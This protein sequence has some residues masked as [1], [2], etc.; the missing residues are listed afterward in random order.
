[1]AKAATA[2]K[3]KEQRVQLRI[4]PKLIPVFAGQAD[5][6]GAKGGR[7]S[8]KTRTFAKMAALF[9]LQCAAKGLEGVIVCGR[10]FM[11]SL[12]DSS[13]A[14]V[15]FAIAEEPW[16]ASRYDVGKNYIRTSD[17]KISFV[18]A[19]LRHNIESIKSK[20]RIRLLWVDEAERVSDYAW[21]ITIPTIREEGAEVWVT[22]NPA[23][24]KSATHKRFWLD[25]PSNSKIVELNWRD[26]PWFPSRL[27]TTRLDDLEKRPDQYEHVWEGGFVTVVEGAY[28][29]KQIA[30]AKLKGRI[31]PV[32]ADPY[33]PL[34]AFVDIGG[35]GARS[36]AVSIF[37]AQFVATRIRVL[38]YYE[39]QGQP[40][41]TH[42]QW[43]RDNKF[44]KAFV[45]LPHDGAT[46]DKVHDVSYESAFRAAQF[47]V[48][49]IPNQGIGAASFRIEALRR[50]FPSID[51]NE[52][53]IT[54]FGALEA[55]GWYHEKRS[56]DDRDIGLGPDHDWSSHCA[57]AAGLMAVVYE[58]PAADEEHR[59]RRKRGSWQGA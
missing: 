49:V 43:M 37:I 18:F 13:F 3:I 53:G 23:R 26:N 15:K 55:L 12:E 22:W 9:G 30:E 41:A 27:N 59:P 24:K 48:E 6:R 38:A 54:E 47:E 31:G 45:Y 32:S 8:A 36:D 5:V 46:N 58:L 28:Y 11:N 16:L 34:K 57:D 14:E 17:G 39:A 21:T 29:A 42:I 51:W 35:T 7:G 52:P 20:A 19:G 50:L 1:M 56:K 2:T 40:L 25:K 10:E 44:E 4:P 33:L